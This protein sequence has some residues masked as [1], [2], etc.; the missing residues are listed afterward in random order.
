MCLFSLS[1]S[2]FSSSLFVQVS[3][4][5]LRALLWYVAHWCDTLP[6]P[7]HISVAL[8]CFNDCHLD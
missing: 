7:I 3:V 8:Y 2:L 1:L 4:V 5:C 6:A